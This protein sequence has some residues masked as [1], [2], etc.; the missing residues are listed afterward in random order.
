[1]AIN[2]AKEELTLALN[3][4]PVVVQIVQRDA[5]IVSK[6]H[7]LHSAHD[8]GAVGEVVEGSGLE[9]VVQLALARVVVVPDGNGAGL[10]A[11]GRALRLDSA[12]GGI[13]GAELEGLLVVT[14]TDSVDETLEG[15]GD[16]AL[17]LL[18]GLAAAS[19]GLV[20]ALILGGD[21]GEEGGGEDEEAGKEHLVQEG[22][23]C[24]PRP[25][26]IHRP[27]VWI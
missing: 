6:A 8:D 17:G 20:V 2:V 11:A 25:L 27:N 9:R 1:M 26:L 24:F 16:G 7:S 23:V 15:G 22:R 4:E 3:R 18:A 21:K 5:V 12:V 19:A 13:G 10:S 14:A